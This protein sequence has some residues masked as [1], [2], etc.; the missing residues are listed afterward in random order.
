M[1]SHQDMG[2]VGVSLL[3]FLGDQQKFVEQEECS[4]IFCSLDTECSLK[5]QLTVANQIRPVPV[6]QQ[7]LNLLKERR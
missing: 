3:A 4:F 6:S 7:T 2:F 1:D 5:N